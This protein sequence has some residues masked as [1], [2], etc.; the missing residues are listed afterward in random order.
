MHFYKPS[1]HVWSA[2]V[3][4][5]GW[6]NILSDRSYCVN[7]E[8]VSN[9]DSG[10]VT[11]FI[12]RNWGQQ[13]SIRPCGKEI[14]ITAHKSLTAQTKQIVSSSITTPLMKVTSREYWLNKAKC[15]HLA[16]YQQGEWARGQSCPHFGLLHL[17]V[18]IYIIKQTRVWWPP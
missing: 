4:E 18:T 2:G 13:N 16:L 9:K 8:L 15:I 3:E 14:I 1:C 10:Q 7:N 12:G 5:K 17:W 6:N 11:L